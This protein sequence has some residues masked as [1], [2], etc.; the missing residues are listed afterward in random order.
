[1][2]YDINKDSDLSEIDVSHLFPVSTTLLGFRK[3]LFVRNFVFDFIQK[4]TGLS[5]E[6]ISRKLK[7][8]YEI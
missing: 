2:A 8:R 1:M 4:F 6:A 5:P 7:D 3:D